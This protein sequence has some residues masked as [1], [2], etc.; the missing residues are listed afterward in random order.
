MNE[1]T[2]VLT[3]DESVANSI[4]YEEFY[5]SFESSLIDITNTNSSSTADNGSLI[6]THTILPF[7]IKSSSAA[8]YPLEKETDEKTT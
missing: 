6:R 1:Q 8:I 2:S 4:P 7:M 5:K 3:T